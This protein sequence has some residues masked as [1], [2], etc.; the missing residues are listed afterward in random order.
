[1]G[2]IFFFTKVLKKYDNLFYFLYTFV[3]LKTGE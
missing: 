3:V 1:M 2:T